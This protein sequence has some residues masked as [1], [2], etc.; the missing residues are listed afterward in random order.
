MI[1]RYLQVGV[2]NT[3]L[4]LLIIALLTNFF[5]VNYNI[6]YFIGYVLGFINSF[7]LN[8]H[9]TFKSSNKWIKEFS[10][11]M[12]IF[13]ISYILSHIILTFLVST[14]EVNVNIAIIFSM[15]TYTIISYFMNKK[16]FLSKKNWS[17]N[18]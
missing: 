1:F 2:V 12:F 18:V 7:V 8:K 14:I 3:L 10:P 17:N 9:Y 15:G 4:T 5:N 16:L 6:S 11:F 13:I